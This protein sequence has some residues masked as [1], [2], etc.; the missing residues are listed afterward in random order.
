MDLPLYYQYGDIMRCP[1]S[2]SLFVFIS[3]L[4]NFAASDSQSMLPLLYQVFGYSFDD[5]STLKQMY[6]HRHFQKQIYKFGRYLSEK[7]VF[8]ESVSLES[9]ISGRVFRVSSSPNLDIEPVFHPM[10]SASAIG[11]SMLEKGFRHF[12]VLESG[13]IVEGDIAYPVTRVDVHDGP[14]DLF[15][16]LY[17]D[18]VDG[19][20]RESTRLMRSEF[21]TDNIDPLIFGSV[22]LEN[23]I[24]TPNI[25]NVVLSDLD[26]DT[27]HL[28]GKYARVETCTDRINCDETDTLAI[29]DASE[30]FCFTPQFD[31]EKQADDPFAEVNT[32]RNISNINAWFRDSFGWE[33]LFNGETWISVKVGQDWDNAGYF[34]GN[35]KTPPYIVFGFSDQ[36]Y[37]YDADAAHHEFGHAVNDFFW[38]HGWIIRDKYGIDTAM[39]SIEEA[40]ADIW[41]F[42]FSKDPVS[43][44]YI[45]ASRSADNNTTCPLS[46]LGEGHYDS[47]ILSGFAWD[48]AKEIGIEP[49]SHIFY[50]TIGFLEKHETFFSFVEK[51]MESTESLSSETGTGVFGWHVDIIQETARMRGL[52]DEA[53]ER[54]LV[55]FGEDELRYAIGYGRNR[56]RK[57]NYPFGFQWE[58]QS[59]SDDVFA[60]LNLEWV[61]PEEDS[62]GNP[63][64]PGYRVYFNKSEPVTV[65]WLEDPLEGEDG[66]EVMADQLYSDSP[67]TVFFPLV[68]DGLL[69]KDDKI[70]VL[71][72]AET[73]EPVIA[74]KG[75]LRFVNESR[76][77]DSSVYPVE[78]GSN[79]R[80]VLSSGCVSIPL[81]Y[82]FSVIILLF[83]VLFP[84]F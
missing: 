1:F 17:V 34:S 73:D 32:Y 4:P 19:R 12:T 78:N 62:E 77:P 72:I 39:Y 52:L 6:S 20:I 26:P 2:L 75:D 84:F 15:M 33:G 65:S 74:L 46:L 70:Y 55:P 49:L 35:S 41:S 8:F 79:A 36:N 31:K 11:R 81:T 50:R 42:S 45:V 82:N 24:T 71:L 64:S 57:F 27:K 69:S 68:S 14:P 44:A 38:Q 66:F 25:A 63:V 22:Y 58:I 9:D 61:F 53:C 10:I 48:V 3:F 18:A 56:T 7:P 43:D 67:S 30:G 51:L 60:Q 23:P 83:E 29:L 16:S 5:E 37:A 28:Y 21:P 54:R 13:W 80:R 59:P 47:R 76:Q 40:L